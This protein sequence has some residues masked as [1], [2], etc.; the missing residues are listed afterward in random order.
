MK[1]IDYACQMQD[2]KLTAL[3]AAAQ[4]STTEQ[5]KAATRSAI[6]A[7]DLFTHCK[8]VGLIGEFEDAWAQLEAG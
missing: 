2:A 1:V 3:K 5:Y 4:V 7:L 6:R 8:K